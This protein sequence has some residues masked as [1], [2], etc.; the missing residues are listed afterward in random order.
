LEENPIEEKTRV[1]GNFCVVENLKLPLSSVKVPAVPP[2]TVTEIAESPS[3]DFVFLTV[4]ERTV[5]P[6]AQAD[7]AKKQARIRT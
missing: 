7:P 6:C 3:R 4:P 5:E 1:K 2:L